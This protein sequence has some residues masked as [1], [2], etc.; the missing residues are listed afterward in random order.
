MRRFASVAVAIL[1]III[2][3]P[4]QPVE[5]QAS[6]NVISYVYLAGT[7]TE[8][9]AI[10]RTG[11]NQIQFVYT[12]AE[13]ALA[14]QHDNTATLSCVAPLGPDHLHGIKLVIPNYFP[15][16]S[17]DPTA[18]GY[19]DVSAG[20]I[21]P[22]PVRIDN[23]TVYA[24]FPTGVIG[25]TI[26]VRYG[27]PTG[28]VMPDRPNRYN[29]TFASRISTTECRYCPPSPKDY[30][31]ATTGFRTVSPTP[32][33]F[34][35]TNMTPATLTF[36]PNTELTNTE[37]T[38]NFVLGA[39]DE[40]SLYAGDIIRIQLDYDGTV[41][42]PLPIVDMLP[43]PPPPPAPFVRT[44]QVPLAIP[45]D[46]V[47]VNNAKCTVSPTITRLGSGNYQLDV[48]IP[49]DIR[50]SNTTG[51]AVTIKFEKQCNIIHGAGAPFERV[52]LIQTLRSNLVPVEP[53]PDVTDGS[54]DG[55]LTSTA[56]R[57]ATK[58]NS[59]GV[60]VI[61]ALVGENAEYYIG[62]TP[63][64]GGIPP[65]V[66]PAC[67]TQGSFQIG[68]NGTL[69]A[70]NGTITF[71]FPAGTTMPNTIAPGSITVDNLTTGSGPN[72]VG[73]VPQLSGRKITIKTPV[74]IY[75]DDCILV[76]FAKSAHIYNPT[77]GDDDYYMRIWTSS[78][79]TVITSMIYSV[80]N[81]GW[82]V[83]NVQPNISFSDGIAFAPGQSGLGLNECAEYFQSAVAPFTPGAKYTVQFSLP[84]DI[85]IPVGGLIDIQFDPIYST[86][87]PLLNYSLVPP[88]PSLYPQ[89]I[90]I[91]GVTCTV[92]PITNLIDS[93]R[94]TSPVVLNPSSQITITLREGLRLYNPDLTDEHESY[95]IKIDY[96][97]L[98]A[99]GAGG[100]DIVSEPYLI[101]TEVSHVHY[102]TAQAINTIAEWRVNFCLGDLGDSTGMGMPNLMPGDTISIMFPEG[103]YVP[104]V[105]IPSGSIQIIDMSIPPPPFPSYF[106]S[107]A[108]VEGNIITVTVPNVAF[109]ENSSLQIFFPESLG[110][111]T[112]S[113]PTCMSV[114]VKTSRETTWIQSD[115][116]CVGTTV[117][118]IGVTTTPNTSESINTNCVISASE[119]TVRFMNGSSGSL[120]PGN[121]ISLAVPASPV[122]NGTNSVGLD[123]DIDDDSAIGAGDDIVM[124]YLLLNGIPN[125]TPL[126]WVDRGDGHYYIDIPV[127]TYIAAGS[128]IQIIIL[129][130]QEIRNPRIDKTP[131][132][133][134]FEMR[135]STEP[136]WI[137]SL[138]F[139]VISKICMDCANFEHLVTFEGSIIT[140]MESAEVWDIGFSIPSLVAGTLG[141]L[142]AGTGTITIEFP[143]D[144]RLPNYI[145][146]LSVFVGPTIAPGS[147]LPCSQVVTD[148]QKLII[149]TPYTF[150]A[151]SEV[152]IQI[153]ET[154]GIL[155]PSTPGDHTLKIWTYA[156]TTPVETCPFTVRARGITPAVVTPI[157]SIAGAPNTK[158]IIKF[159]V[160]QYGALSIGDTITL[161][162]FED[163]PGVNTATDIVTAFG[164]FRIPA[165]FV[166]VNGVSCSLPI[167]YATNNADLYNLSMHVRTPISI[168]P[169]GEVEIVLSKDCRITNPPDPSSPN[170]NAAPPLVGEPNEF[171]ERNANDYFVDIFTNK[172]ITPIRSLE[173]EIT[174]DNICTRPVTINDP[175]M[176]NATA[177]YTISFYTHRDLDQSVDN[178][179]LRFPEG[180]YLPNRIAPN[181]IRVN[182]YLCTTPPAISDYFLTILVPE[183]IK[184]YEKVTIEFDSQ[185]GLQ[186]LDREGKHLLRVS[187][188]QPLVPPVDAWIGQ[189]FTV[190]ES[191][192]LCTL[193]ITTSVGRIQEVTVPK[194][195]IM[196]FTAQAFDCN[197]VIINQDTKYSWMFVPDS[198][199]YA[200][201]GHISPLEG[202]VTTFTAGDMGDG[203]LYCYATYG[204][205]TISSSVKIRI[206]GEASSLI[207]SP[208]GPS[209]LIKGDCYHYSAQLYDNNVPPHA[210]TSGVVYTWSVTNTSVAGVSPEISQPTQLC[211]IATGAG[212]ITCRAVYNNKEIISRSD[213]TVKAGI[214]ALRP[215]PT[216]DLGQLRVGQI[217]TELS[218]ELMDEFGAPVLAKETT[219]V[220][221][222]STSPT[223][224][225]STDKIHWTT[226]NKIELEIVQG[227]A[228]SQTFFFSD[229]RV[230]NVSLVGS[231]LDIVSAN[232]RVRLMGPVA[233]INFTNSYIV[234]SASS[235]TD[236]LTIS[237]I[238]EYGMISPPSSDITILMTSHLIVGGA[239]SSQT[240]STGEFSISDIN[241]SP[242][243]GGMLTLRS[244][245]QSIDVYYKDNIKGKY[246]IKA[247]T[248]FN[249]EATQTL[250]ITDETGV[251]GNLIVEVLKPIAGVDSEYIIDF[252]TGGG[253]SLSAGSGH[254]YLKF[255]T[256]TIIPS[257]SKADITVNGTAC[258][259]APIID[260]ATNVIDIITPVSVNSNTD[261]RVKIPRII[262]PPEGTYSME[263]WTSSQPR[264]VPSRVYEIGVS[265]VSNLRV[266]VAPNSVGLAGQYTI[267]FKTGPS[268]QLGINDPITIQF[269]VG[270]VVPSSIN[271]DKIT[272]NGVLCKMKPFVQGL[273]MTIYNPMPIQ[274]LQDVGMIIDDLAGIKNP[275]IAKLGYT[276]KL[277][278]A[279][280]SKFV[281]SLPYEIT[282]VSTLQNV[283]V[284]V[285]PPT[286]NKSA[287]YEINFQIGSNGSLIAGDKISIQ[288]NEQTL[289]TAIPKLYVSINGINPAVDVIIDGKRLEIKL[290]QGIASG[291][292]VSLILESQAGIRNP[293]KPGNDYRISIFTSKE[294]Y[295]VASQPFSIESELVV[296]YSISPSVPNGSRGWYTTPPTI[297]LQCNVSAN[298]Q[299]RYEG[300][301]YQT[302][303]GPFT[304][305]KTGQIVIYYKAISLTSGTESLEK[306]IL[307]KYDPAKPDV[308]L[309][310]FGDGNK[311]QVKASS[312]RICGSI[313]DSSDVEL[314]MNGSP[315]SINSDGTF[316]VNV[317]LVS[318]ENEFEFCATD[319]AGNTICKII[320]VEKKDKPPVLIIDE[321][322]FMVRVSKTEFPYDS[323]AN[324][325]QL[326]VVLHV[327]GS[328]EA[329][330]SEIIITPKTVMGE[331]QKLTVAPDGKFEGDVTFNAIGGLNVFEAVATD[332]LGNVA[333]ANL[334]PVVSVDFRLTIN[335]TTSMLNGESVT[336]LSAPYISTSWR[337]MVP[338]RVMGE[339][340]GAE[341][342]W[343][344]NTRTASFTMG[345]ISIKLMVN[346]SKA[347]VIKNGVAKTVALDAPAVIVNSSLMVPF[348]FIAENF[349]A[350]VSWNNDTKTAT[351]VYP[352]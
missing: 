146:P 286:I 158:Y 155:T 233:R 210:I 151:D 67:G 2:M 284:K 326:K 347:T 9:I 135:T 38:V 35:M 74:D 246:I 176:T 332:K 336:L 126:S 346:S 263:I 10:A 242:L 22:N 104:A 191:R 185:L 168:P 28:I 50:C 256:G 309:P 123:I 301:D 222:E 27:G 352:K 153:S 84:E 56:Y 162:F 248:I 57:I 66:I 53:N 13:N 230:G 93:I 298:I 339:A 120:S 304:I 283:V 37:M 180:F 178:I 255:P 34:V 40:R 281:D 310:E 127:Q 291:Q 128:M 321:P 219:K 81:P 272:V 33:V 47:K 145:D 101:K 58:L 188:R 221:V 45:K 108:I 307:L 305:T 171:L 11:G 92:P 186:N 98:G 71:E 102:T 294:P 157:T 121:T 342:G 109:V 3:V 199:S 241:W 76:H 105:T 8:A 43:P 348:R 343:D 172:E 266:N 214:F 46:Y 274:A 132:L 331:S 297:T 152:R 68:G 207:I 1:M 16:P 213:F 217:S 79:P 73:S 320:I 124:G 86:L 205:K 51:R 4:F 182:G 26:I 138:P 194:G 70:D 12:L 244:G 183:S 302:Y 325:Y 100:F 315:V 243:P 292:N 6:G 96:L 94:I 129:N 265:T 14:Q 41:I 319:F 220:I 289:P 91:N 75:P 17:L 165:E 216:D 173:Y 7:T 296:S 290:T 314:T 322:G 36:N 112:P 224:R 258:Q 202:R 232:I 131:S 225:F 154:A 166:T 193:K 247:T 271:P 192:T 116:V 161:A 159:K 268:G 87:I 340:I 316:C 209:T 133:Y 344:G 78:E 330:I 77:V 240:S 317:A 329:G 293:P 351:M 324:H 295:A 327:K 236:K 62:A 318:G 25:G 181:M 15:L 227:F 117:K 259:H 107:G 30:S 299:Y 338:F 261:V 90:E 333:V 264:H 54:P 60:T 65:Y 64:P 111:K 198:N 20:T 278:T 134:M 287:R 350:S 156:E 177:D 130:S 150:T 55:F 345:D 226:T 175:C 141:T 196:D 275:V 218:F 223:S 306:D 200:I 189:H 249:G 99:V 252:R 61:P 72:V 149:T 21:T 245:Q 206:S 169:G 69:L 215:Y 276:L 231:A 29:F 197:S 308:Q 288:M 85:T 63:N 179:F 279:S 250:D 187:D 103:T 238:D 253:G 24:Y 164:N 82:A 257:L 136:A 44:V 118:D 115:P 341:I 311:I 139:E 328:T 300:E 334:K 147:R 89:F 39:G 267:E 5:V 234:T 211:P 106:V 52:A 18:E 190:C 48:Y 313:A 32:Q 97:P 235:P 170:T 125:T 148:G 49:R 212:A 95:N 269:P 59:P 270:T 208:G 31:S 285:N 114:G 229:S 142:A 83:V 19:I 174:P 80:V 137:R 260:T 113:D 251:E 303:N 201:I 237:L 204:N 335:Q 273:Q 254:I 167:D 143:P 203:T 110:I 23:R 349:G 277:A 119:Y 280:D 282:Q 262:N 195:G 239:I 144:V 42:P 88:P 228:K 122:L 337:T 160:G 323:A 140:D 312:H 184:Q 163:T